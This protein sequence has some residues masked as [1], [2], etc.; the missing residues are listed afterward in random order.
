M[1]FDTALIMAADTI[2]GY[3]IQGLLH[4]IE[5]TQTA[6]ARKLISRDRRLLRLPFAAKLSRCNSGKSSESASEMRRVGVARRKCDIDNLGIRV[7]QKF[8]SIF[9]A[10]PVK[11]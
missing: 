2:S 1:R 4:G 6:F 8:S 11:E 10:G 3:I 7:A 5:F 9:K